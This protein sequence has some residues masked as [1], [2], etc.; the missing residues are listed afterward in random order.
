MALSETD[1][2]NLALGKNG[3]AGDSELGTAFIASINAN[4]KVAQWLK[5]N[6]PRARRRAI[7]DLATRQCPFRSTVKFKDLGAQISSDDVP[8]IG[9]YQFA[10][11]LPG[12]CLE[13]SMQFYEAAIAKR[14]VRGTTVVQVQWET[15]ADSAGTGKILLTNLLTNLDGTSSFIEYVIDVKNTKAFSE[16]MVDCIATLLASE[17]GPTVGWGP[18]ISTLMLTKYLQIAIPNAQRANQRGFDNSVKPVPDYSG[19][20]SAG[21]AF[22][23]VNVGLGTFVNAEGDRRNILS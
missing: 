6:L 18:E 10:F 21:V 17:V 8:E 9:E 1:I 4:N 5:F 14:A 11:N 7:I 13:V 19:G 16:E 23:A 20:R 3:G 15:V 22:P 2:A 12:D